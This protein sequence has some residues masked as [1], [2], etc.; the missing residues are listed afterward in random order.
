MAD[1]RSG[2][3]GRR[4]TAIRQAVRT[5][6]RRPFSPHQLPA[7]VTRPTF[8]R[9]ASRRAPSLPEALEGRTLMS[10]Y[11][12]ATNGSDSADGSAGAPFRTIQQAANRAQPGDTVLVHGGTY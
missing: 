5:D 2:G 11:Y 4:I 7:T 12:V 3:G 8:A 9:A 10:T 1:L 6:D